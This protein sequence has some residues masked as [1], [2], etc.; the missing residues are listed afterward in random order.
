M[1]VASDRAQVDL[2]LLDFWL[3]RWDVVSP[4]REPLG[5]NEIS[6]VLGGAAL[7][8][9]WRDVS[10][11]EGLSL[12]YYDGPGGIWKQVWVTDTGAHKE[13]ALVGHT[14][15]G[16]VIFQGTIRRRAGGEYLDRTVLTP[17]P[18]RAVRQVIETS[19]DAGA[20]WAVGFEGLYV[21]RSSPSGRAL[22]PDT[23]TSDTAGR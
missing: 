2:H 1:V 3:G 4:T 7:I 8:E 16:G 14:A 18:D 21:R 15:D 19:I 22:R 6:W 9:R 10:G 13:K 20:T 17:L 12:F 5:E 11:H 23:R